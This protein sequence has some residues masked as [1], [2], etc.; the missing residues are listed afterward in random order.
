MRKPVVI[1]P[2]L[3]SPEA[4]A[5]DTRALN[6]RIIKE[7]SAAPPLHTLPPEIIR[8]AREKGIGIWGPYK[9]LDSVEVREI[10]GPAGPVVV[11]IQR[12][13]T[14]KGVYLHIHG[15][16]FVLGRAHHYDELMSFI[17][18]GTGAVT[19][20]VDYRLAPENPYPAGPD[21]CEAAARWVIENAEKE[22]GTGRVVI[23]GESAGANLAAVTML[24][25]RDRHGYS[26]FAGANLV[27]GV[28][29][30][31]LTPS[32]RNWGDTPLILTTSLMKWFNDHY[33][34]SDKFS[35][36]D[37]SP[38]YADLKGLAP[39]LFTVGTKDP[40]MDDT[41]FMCARWIESGNE[42]RLAVYPGGCHGFNAFDITAAHE[43]HE[44]AL[45]FMNGCFG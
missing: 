4:V 40:L 36:P 45:D 31:N 13:D 37:V 21:D 33:T 10:P 39:A 23:G 7:M 42:A 17:S 38:L 27:Y 9:V 44:L 14:I 5:E 18:E 8:D 25:M 16:G 41:L 35:D 22:F 24:R 3:F 28:F 2:A 19:V 29:D 34:T 12:P 43:A 20:S 15:G 1:D 26:G 6:D 32:A 11:R 30:L